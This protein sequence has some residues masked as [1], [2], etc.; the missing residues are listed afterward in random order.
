MKGIQYD[1]VHVMP[2]NQ[3]IHLRLV[4]FRGGTVPALKIDG[5]RIQ[6]SRSIA[7]ELDA[8]APEPRLFPA[9]P[10]ERRRVE[11]AERWG[12]EEFQPVPRRLLRWALTRDVHLREWLGSADGSIP[13]ASVV[14]RVTGPVAR[15]YAWIAGAD[16]DQ[17]R[18]DVAELP[19]KLDRVGEFLESGAATTDAPNAATLQLL[20]TVRALLGFADF[21]QLVGARSYAPLAR[22][23]FP[24]FPGSSFPPF[25]ERLGLA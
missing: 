2:G 21:E 14:A 20:C 11:E 9:D 23:L 5:A 6:G 3:R 16:E 8:L 12:D 15:Y 25:V 19:G 1:S 4:G 13:A 22:E 17:V 24:D 7:R 10:G 18:R